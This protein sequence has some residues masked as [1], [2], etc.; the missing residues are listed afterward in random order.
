V[1]N[2]DMSPAHGSRNPGS[3]HCPTDGDM[4]LN[5]TMKDMNTRESCMKPTGLGALYTVGWVCALPLEMSA[6][7]ATFDEPTR[8]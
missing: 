2:M 5:N 1:T 6:A 8:R 7:V 4:T 3:S